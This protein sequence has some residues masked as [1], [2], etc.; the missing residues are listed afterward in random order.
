MLPP[1]YKQFSHGY[2]VTAHR[3]QGQ[4]V[5]SVVISGDRMHKELFYVAASRGRESIGVVTSDK[6]L[7]RETIA[8]S[9]SRQ[10]ASELAMR[11][12]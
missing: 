11:A 9:D 7:L 3:S 12:P 6:E 1:D 8:Q 10:S 4:S 5:D 2:A